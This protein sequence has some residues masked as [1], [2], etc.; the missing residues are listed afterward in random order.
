[1]FDEQLKELEKAVV[2][3][4]NAVKPA[5]ATEYWLVI[6]N[7]EV[8]AD[9]RS[10]FNQCYEDAVQW[11]NDYMAIEESLRN[12]QTKDFDFEFTRYYENDDGDVIP[13]ERVEKTYTYEEYHGDATE[14]CTY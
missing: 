10:T 5:D 14:H 6:R 1:M 3:A 7:D 9:Y 13:L 4:G 11:A 8:I 12:G 2:D